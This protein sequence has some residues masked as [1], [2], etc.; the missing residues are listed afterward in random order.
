MQA[1][2]ARTCDGR[3]CDDEPLRVRQ[4][5]RGLFAELADVSICVGR[6]SF[7]GCCQWASVMTGWIMD[8][9]Y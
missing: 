2:I 6:S 9:C 4:G 5:R 3:R 1:A 7:R 8:Y